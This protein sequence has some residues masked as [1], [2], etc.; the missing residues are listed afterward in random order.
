[1]NTTFEIFSYPFMQ[2]AFIA[3][4]AIAIVAPLIGSFLVLK[5]YALIADALSHITLAGIAVAL[6]TKTEPLYVT[7][8][9][10]IGVSL[11][12]EFIRQTRRLQGDAVLA[13]FLPGGLAISVVLLS[14]VKSPNAGITNYLFGSITTL[15]LQDAFITA[16]LSA[17]IALGIASVYDKLLFASYDEETAK[18]S[19]IQT[20]FLNT[21][22]MILTAL[23]VSISFR[24]IGAL[25]V[26]AL[27][28]IPVVSA[29]LL[30]SSFRQTIT[31]AMTIG[32]ASVFLGLLLSFFINIPTGST[33]VLIS[34]LFFAL[35]F[36]LTL[37]KKK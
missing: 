22:L 1:M 4:G 31:M 33:V 5:R 27:M 20:S 10:C 37:G 21:L 35:S 32:A 18:A 9:L 8:L 17:G 34:L 23:T 24:I 12:L 29:Q 7:I 25:L 11:L 28:V 15:G 30:A 19:G 6:I 16:F 26:G 2:A 13:M 3:G 14:L 36:L